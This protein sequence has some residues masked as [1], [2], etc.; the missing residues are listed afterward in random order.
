MSALPIREARIRELNDRMRRFWFLPQGEILLTLCV[1]ELDPEEQAELLHKVW[2]F[3][4]FTEDNDPHGEHDFGSIDHNG[5]RY[6]WKIDY[7]DLQKEY[8]SPDPT[9]PA[10][11]CRVLTIM[12]A[13]EY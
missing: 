5:A 10:V 13:D 7:Y 3:D 6:F 9:D 11:T 12:R 2:T 1:Q 8:G 4:A